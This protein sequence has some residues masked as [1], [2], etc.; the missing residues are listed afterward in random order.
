MASIATS[1]SSHAV[2]RA[3]AAAANQR[4]RA[5]IASEYAVLRN[6]ARRASGPERSKAVTALQ[7]A[8]HLTQ[9]EASSATV[10]VARDS[11]DARIT[12]SSLP[13]N[14]V[15]LNVHDVK[16]QSGSVGC[17]DTAFAG[18][19]E[20][21]LAAVDYIG[22]DQWRVT[23][24]LVDGITSMSVTDSSGTRDI[25][26]SNNV[27]TTVVSPGPF[28]LSWTAPDG[29]AQHLGATAG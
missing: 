13:S 1:D 12:L 28:S 16:S 17:T 11:E 23:V 5:S 6:A 26:V 22:D 25:A 24:M 27:A 20:R 9:A 21:P 18:D 29:T 14:G 7:Q 8:F 4:Q 2:K 10:A 3:A 19:A 15:C